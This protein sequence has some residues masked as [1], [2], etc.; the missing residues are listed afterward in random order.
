MVEACDALIVVSPEHAHGITAVMKNQLDG[1][2]GRVAF[3]GKPVAVNPAL[4]SHHADD[5]LREALRTMSA[6]SVPAACMRIP[7][8][9][10]GLEFEADARGERFTADILGVFAALSLPL[11]DA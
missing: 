2:V 7:V 10:S 3:V 1:L 9:G 5:A 11:S 4:D 8:I 6:A